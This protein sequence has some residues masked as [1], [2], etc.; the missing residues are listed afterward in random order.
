MTVASGCTG[1]DLLGVPVLVVAVGQHGGWGGISLVYLMATA[2]RRRGLD[3]CRP[4]K[5]IPPGQRETST[6]ALLASGARR[7]AG[8][9]CG[10]CTA[11]LSVL[12]RLLGLSHAL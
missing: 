8:A 4:H 7:F 10:S 9:A 3:I 11:P 5:S 2:L 1:G 6:Q 12:E